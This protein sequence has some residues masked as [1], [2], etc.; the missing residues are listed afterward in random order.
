MS[1]LGFRLERQARLDLKDYPV[2]A[3]WSA[4]ERALAVACGQGAVLCFDVPA[5]TSR[6]LGEH[7]GGALAVGWRPPLAWRQSPLWHQLGLPY[8]ER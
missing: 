5:G 8:A 1:G 3:C 7:P 2:D 6:S 4:D